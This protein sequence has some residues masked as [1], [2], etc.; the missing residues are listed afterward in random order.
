MLSLK[1]EN[2]EAF[3]YLD[4]GAPSFDDS[5]GSNYRNRNKSI[6]PE[7]WWSFWQKNRKRRC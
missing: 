1:E 5:Y 2:L 4:G 6:M 3:Q 7:N